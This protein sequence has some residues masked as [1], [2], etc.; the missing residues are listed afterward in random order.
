MTKIYTWFCLKCKILKENIFWYRL[1]GW[2][3]GAGGQA[4]WDIF[5]AFANKVMSPNGNF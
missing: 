1:S 4:D 3:V 2:G 5:A